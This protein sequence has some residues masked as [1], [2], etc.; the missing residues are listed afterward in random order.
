MTEPDLSA[1]LVRATC[2]NCG[3]TGHLGSNCERRIK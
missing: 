3:A 1:E 2:S